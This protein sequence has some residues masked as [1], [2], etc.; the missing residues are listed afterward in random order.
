MAGQIGK[1]HEFH[2]KEEEWTQYVERLEHFFAAN[3]HTEAN[4]KKSILLTA[5]GPAAYKLL[6]SLVSPAKPGDKSYDELVDVMQ[7]HHSRNCSTI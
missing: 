3:G 7:T 2:E 6:R 1:T 4:K 5:I